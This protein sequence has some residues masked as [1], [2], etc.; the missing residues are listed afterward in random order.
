MINI[1]RQA[2]HQSSYGCIRSLILA[3]ADLGIPDGG[4]AIL[5]R[6]ILLFEKKEDARLAYVVLQ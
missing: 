1:D 4:K 2:I 5:G 6:T 3:G